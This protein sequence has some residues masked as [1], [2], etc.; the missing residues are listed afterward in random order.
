MSLNQCNFIGR[1][2]RPP[3]IRYTPS[4]D[5]V[6]NFSMACSESWKD[7]TGQKQEKTEWVNVVA[8]R[9]LAEIIGQYVGKGDL[10]FI[11]GKMQTR[12]W[13]DKDGGKRSTTE[14]VAGEMKMLGTKNGDGVSRNT[15][16]GN[17]DMGDVPF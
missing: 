2:G 12:Q 17:S 5:A 14:I 3:E 16:Q 7:K 6:A 1:V 4:G 13:E 10:I 11:S 8:W 9:R 15:P